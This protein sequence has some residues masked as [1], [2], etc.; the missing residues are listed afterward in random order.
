MNILVTNDDGVGNPGIWAL[1]RAVKQLGNVTV[2]APA[3]NQSGTG[4]ALSFRKSI[5][6]NEVESQVQGVPCYAVEGT[7]G[8]SAVIGI[9]QV[10]GNQVD[11]V[12]SGINPGNNT[13][14]H[15]LISGTLGAATIACLNGVKSA[16]FS[17][18]LLEE[19]DDPLIGRITTAITRELISAETPPAALFNINFPTIRTGGITGAEECRPAPSLLDMKIEKHKDGGYEI[20]S[21]IAVSWDGSRLMPGTDLEVLDRGCVAL[22]AVNVNGNMPNHTPNDQTL[23]RQSLGRMVAAASSAIG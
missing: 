11:A 14:G 9:R 3:S 20:M 10:L 22:T 13:S 1:V 7:P 6:V 16:A 17:S 12:V 2:V 21:R 23:G 18:A 15:Y 5:Q 8:D 4:A 19:V